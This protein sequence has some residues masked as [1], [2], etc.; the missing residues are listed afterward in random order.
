MKPSAAPG[1]FL[2]CFW[3]ST[4]ICCV[5]A[6][7]LP[8]T[9]TST[10]A[11]NPKLSVWLVMSAG[12]KKNVSCGKSQVYAAGWKADVVDDHRQLPGRNDAPYLRIH[13]GEVLRRYF[14]A[15]AARR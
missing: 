9:R 7:S 4:A 6:A 13:A 15:R 2:I 1:T 10:G 8:S 12:S 5:A 11:G 14:D 3:S